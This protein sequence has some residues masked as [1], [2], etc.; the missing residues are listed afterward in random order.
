MKKNFFLSTSVL[1]I[2]LLHAQIGIKTEN[3]LTLFHIDGRGDN[4]STP[5]NIQT[6]NDFVTTSDGNVGIGTI[7]PTVKLE[8]QT[9]GMPIGTTGGFKLSDGS[10][11][12]GKFMRSDPQ[13]VGSWNSAMDN[14]LVWDSN[15]RFTIPHTGVY[16]ITLHMSSKSINTSYT[17]KWENPILDGGTAFNGVALF[18]IT[19]GN[20]LISNANTIISHSSYCSGTLI[21]NAGEIIKP[22][23]IAW[24]TT[25]TIPAL[26]VEII[27]K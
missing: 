24:M 9:N 18:S 10:Q 4:D 8:I 21:L 12:I 1:W 16:L 11:G 3:P 13:G 14:A 26:F 15:H 7:T 19:R 27:P 17:N 25:A 23:A 2:G 22:S 6:E 20:Y 5:T